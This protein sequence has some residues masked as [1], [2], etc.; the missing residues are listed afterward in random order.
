MGGRWVRVAMAALAVAV[1]AESALAQTAADGGKTPLTGTKQA[2]VDISDSTG[3]ILR[4]G[5]TA[6]SLKIGDGARDRDLDWKHLDI[7]NATLIPGN[8]AISSA[9]DTRGWER[10][11]IVLY[12]SPE[13]TTVTAY[14]A[15]QVRGGYTAASDS[16]SSFPWP[17]W[18]IGAASS[19]DTIGSRA[20]SVSTSDVTGF[21]VLQ[22]VDNEFVVRVTVKATGASP[23]G[24]TAHSLFIPLCRNGVWWSAPYTTVRVRPLL[25]RIAGMGAATSLNSKT[26]RVDLVGWR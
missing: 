25:H 23:P 10:A 2:V 20:D 14:F 22:T 13:D 3:V 9:K 12:V 11:G 15:V 16:L 26:Y 19:P 7:I 8:A 18:R 5:D 21:P 4:E 17:E 1:L 6:G 24:S